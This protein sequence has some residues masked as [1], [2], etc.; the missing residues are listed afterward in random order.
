MKK[1]KVPKISFTM[2]R[3][4]GNKEAFRSFVKGMISDYLNSDKLTKLQE[5]TLVGN[6]EISSK[7]K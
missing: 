7:A 5:N 3:Y 2:I 6:V 1:L 4:S